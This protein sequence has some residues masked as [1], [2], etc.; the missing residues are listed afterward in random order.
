MV[1][2]G[3]VPPST[4]FC[5]LLTAESP[6]LRID[7]PILC[8]ETRARPDVPLTSPLA[9]PRPSYPVTV[10]GCHEVGPRT[11]SPG[12]VGERACQSEKTANPITTKIV[13]VSEL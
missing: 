3:R 11:T 4:V 12:T 10:P 6:I 8:T 7:P 2:A 1:L 13:V 5:R 9:V